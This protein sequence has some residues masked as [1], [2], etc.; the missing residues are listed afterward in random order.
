MFCTFFERVIDSK[1][2]PEKTPT[3][4]SVTVSGNLTEVIF[5]QVYPPT[6]DTRVTVKVVPFPSGT[7]PGITKCPTTVLSAF[8]KAS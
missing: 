3:S 5:S 2:A 7:V 8:K 6:K 4:K 1:L